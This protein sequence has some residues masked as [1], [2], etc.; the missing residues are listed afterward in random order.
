MGKAF[1]PLCPKTGTTV[2]GKVR[3][4]SKV[5]TMVEGGTS[6]RRIASELKLSKNTV[7][8]IVKRHREA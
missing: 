1:L 6:Y 4:T 7:I 5:L 8:E 2:M 3:L